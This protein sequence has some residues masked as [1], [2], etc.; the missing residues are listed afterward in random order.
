MR[1]GL[2]VRVARAGRLTLF[3]GEVDDVLAA[4]HT[5]AAPPSIDASR[6]DV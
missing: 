3:H 1:R 4:A 2:V 5:L 6:I